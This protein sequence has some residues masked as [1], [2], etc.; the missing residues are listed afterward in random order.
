[1]KKK[2]IV[3]IALLAFISLISLYPFAAIKA[4]NSNGDR[5][6]LNDN[7]YTFDPSTDVFLFNGHPVQSSLS[8]TLNILYSYLEPDES[9]YS[10]IPIKFGSDTYTAYYFI[11]N[12]FF[13]NP[14]YKA[15]AKI[16]K[17]LFKEGSMFETNAIQAHWWSPE[18][19]RFII[20]IDSQGN[21]ISD[22]DNF[23]KVGIALRDYS[24]VGSHSG[25]TVSSLK[26]G[27]DSGVGKFV[28]S[29]SLW[30]KLEYD[31]AFA[32]QKINSIFKTKK[33]WYKEALMQY[34]SKPDEET[35]AE[36]DSFNAKL[37]SEFTKN[38]IKT[39]KQACSIIQ[40]SLKMAKNSYLFGKH[41]RDL[42]KESLQTT[43]KVIPA[44][45]YFSI[46]IVKLILLESES[47]AISDAHLTNLKALNK[48]I[49][50][51]GG[52]DPVFVS[53]LQEVINDAQNEL[54]NQVD[55]IKE[56]VLQTINEAGV[57]FALKSAAKVISTW[58]FKKFG[59]NSI[60]AHTVASGVWIIALGY[61]ISDILY[62]TSEMY[63]SYNLA[64]RVYNIQNYAF[65][66][67]KYAVNKT[68]P[69]SINSNT[70]IDGETDLE[71]GELY[72]TYL[73]FYDLVFY[74]SR[75]MFRNS[76]ALRSVTK[77]LSKYLPHYVADFDQAIKYYDSMY[78]GFSKRENDFIAVDPVITTAYSIFL[79]RKPH[80]TNEK[81][82]NSESSNTAILLDISGS[83]GHMWGNIVKLDAAKQS[84]NELLKMIEEENSSGA[85]NNVG[86]IAFSETATV[87]DPLSTSLENDQKDVNKLLPDGGTDIG[88]ALLKAY[89]MLTAG[90]NNKN[91]FVFLLTDGMTN[92][93]PGKDEIINSIVPKF[94]SN[95][96][97]IYTIG[98][99]SKGDLDETF[100][101]N[102]A[103]ASHGQYFYVTEAWK[104]ENVFISLR[105]QSMGNIVGNFSGTI[106]QGEKVK[107]GTIP[108][109]KDN[110]QLYITL[111]W[112][113]SKLDL[114]LVDPAGKKVD[115]NY[116]GAKIFNNSKPVYAVI[117]NA[118]KGDWTAYVYGEN[119]PE[120]QT[121][122]NVVSSVRVNSTPHTNNNGGFPVSNNSGSKFP[123]AVIILIFAILSGVTVAAVLISTNSNKYQIAGG[124]S[125]MPSLINE[126]GM[127]IPIRKNIIHIGRGRYNDLVLND[128][129]A[130]SRHAEIFITANG[131]WYIRDL[132][133]KNGTYL[134]GKKVST[135][136]I[137]NGDIIKIGKSKFRFIAARNI[138]RMELPQHRK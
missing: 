6:V 55:I 132:K 93:G 53:A 52:A 4:D 39:S 41:F 102:I 133:S 51:M 112:P 7:V 17:Y 80:Q 76:R 27:F 121:N 96:I 61:T 9:V 123:I 49:Q 91:S 26:I 66:T 14:K 3:L 90:T 31:A 104:L 117:K 65:D 85:Q 135:A 130:S 46:P 82:L 23:K 94:V 21:V 103:S 44:I 10:T 50:E 32:D 79:S 122:F 69:Q 8:H 75:E 131:Q 47:F 86:I 36:L 74:N 89:G 60:M 83:M 29:Q 114:I 22:W 24:M 68:M 113:G 125:T 19:I 25:S 28:T 97:K 59:A 13:E 92:R 45:K 62:G 42:A 40:N 110:E 84:A 16:Y 1:M 136:R 109:N 101:K 105:H 34:L 99:G 54:Y 106:K 100:L 111:N 20:I 18:A 116:K 58:A 56:V 118:I 63:D 67:L 30:Q 107:A 64:V 48:Y 43:N 95:G 137:K 70:V 81:I 115:S 108:V 77:I 127:H 37:L 15:N 120:G 73:S 129:Y 134:N 98:I 71:L 88:D 57:D 38:N 78:K 5:I 138:P 87:I 33:D 35:K 128:V 72:D 12:A 2:I 124:I 119:V 11:N 126:K